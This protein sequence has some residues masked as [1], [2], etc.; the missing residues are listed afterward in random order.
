MELKTINGKNLIPSE[1]NPR[2]SFDEDKLELLKKSM[3]GIG[4]LEPL[5]VRSGKDG[6]FF[7][8]AGERRWKSNPESD[9][10]CIVR[11][12]NDLKAKVSC[13][14]ENFVREN[15]P[16]ADHEKFIS[17]IYNEGKKQK[18]WVTAIE[19]ETKTGIPNQLISSNVLAHHDRESL[20]IRNFGN[21]STWDIMQKMTLNK[22]MLSLTIFLFLILLDLRGYN[23]RR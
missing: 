7:I 1:W 17:N 20:G 8:T 19:M 21:V 11:D 5:V 9:F 14:V 23:D 22:K 18:E 4:L 2:S 12:E 6:K 15:I 3:D 10:T 13:L 16:D